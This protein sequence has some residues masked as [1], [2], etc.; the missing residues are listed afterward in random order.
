M[1]TGTKSRIP[2]DSQHMLPHTCTE[3]PMIKEIALELQSMKKPTH[4]SCLS[5]TDVHS[6]ATMNSIIKGGEG[7]MNFDIVAPSS[8]DLPY[9][10]G[11][12][13]QVLD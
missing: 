5:C 11:H 8:P 7:E 12:V 10:R 9:V 2:K 1:P 4:Q 13:F 6:K 3:H